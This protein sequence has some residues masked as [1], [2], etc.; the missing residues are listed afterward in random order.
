MTRH[1]QTLINLTMRL[2][3]VARACKAAADR[4]AGDFDLSHA[5][6]WPMIMN[7]T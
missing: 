6:A 4:M 1:D 5:T 2:T 7:A 3:H